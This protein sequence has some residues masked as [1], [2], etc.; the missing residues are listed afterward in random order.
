[1]FDFVTIS[2]RNKRGVVEIYPKFIIKKSK[3]L[4]IRGGDF[5]AAW[6]EEEKRWTTDEEELI[7]LIDELL[8]NYA[9]NNKSKFPDEHLAISHMWDADSGVIDK[10]HKYVQKQMRDN[11]KPL[12]NK[13]IF[14]DEESVKEDYSSIKLP[15]ALDDKGSIESYSNLISTLYSE[16]D[17]HKIEWCVGAIVTGASKRIH[18]F[19]V[20]YGPPGSGKSTLLNIIQMLF[21]GYHS[22][23]SA[24]ALG[25]ASADFSLA[26]F[27][28]NPLVAISH[29]DDLSRIEKNERLNSLTSHETMVV[30]EKHKAQYNMSFNSFLF[31]GTNKPVKITDSKSGIMRRLIDIYPSGDKLTLNMYNR[32]MN[33]I[34]FELGAIAHHCKQVYLQDPHAYD[35]YKP[36]LMMGES[37]DFY[38]F[39]LDSYRI[40]STDDGTTLKAAWEM[41][42]QYCDVAKVPY[43]FSMRI[44]K[45]ELNNY[46]KKYEE[47]ARID[48]VNVRSYYSIFKIEAF[49]SKPK[50]KPKDRV[51]ED[52][53]IIFK[54]QPSKL[55]TFCSNSPA[56]YAYTTGKQV[57]M[58]K[59]AKVDTILS[60]IDTSKL[61]YLKV[62]ENLIVVDFDITDEDGNKS[63]EENLKA[64]SEWPETY[65][66]LSK[67]GGGIHLHYIYNG[68]PTLLSRI[69]AQHIEI[70]VFTGN[71]SLRRMVTKCNDKDIATISSGL[72][73]RGGGKMVNFEAIKNE[74]ALRTII[75]KNLNKDYHSGTKP[76]V[77]FIFKALDDAYKNGMKYDVSDLHGSVIAFA[78]SSTNQSDYCMKLVPKM[79]FKSDEPSDE[80]IDDR[81]EKIIFYDIE[82]FPNLFVLN[83]KFRGKGKKINRMINPSSKEVEALLK[84]KMIGFN[85][86]RYDNHLVYAKVLG[87]SNMELFILSQ[88]IIMD[89]KGFFAEAWNISYTDVYDY[90]RKKQSLKKWQIE[91]GLHHQELGLPWDE[92]VPQVLWAKVAAYCD[93]DVLATEEVF[94]HTQGD[95][96]ARQILAELTGLSVNSTTNTLSTRL[97]FGKN[98]KPELNYVDLSKEFPGYEFI[99][100]WDTVNNKYIKRNMYRGKDLGFGGYVMGEPGMYGNVALIDV[101]SMHPNSIILMKYLGEYTSVFEELVKVRLYI[102]EGNLEAA[103]KLFGGRLAK[104]LD[105]PELAEDLADALKIV[106]NSVYGLTSA[107]FDNAFRDFRNENNIVALRGALFMKTLEDTVREKGFK[108]AH[109]KTDSIKIPDAT[110]EIIEFCK[111][112]ATKYGYIFEHEATY[113]RMALVNNAVYI[114][115]YDEHGLRGKNGKHANEWT[116]TGTQFA[117]PYVFKTLFS[118][119]QVD[120]HDLAETKEVKKGALYLN[121]NEGTEE[122]QL[123]FIGRVGLFSPVMPGHGGGEL[124]KPVEKKDGT[125]SYDSV[126]GA[127]GYRWLE[128]EEIIEKKLDNS[129]DMSFYNKM[130]DKAID[131]IG[132]FGDAEWFISGDKYQGPSLVNGH[133]DYNQTQLQIENPFKDSLG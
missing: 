126:T 63:F 109:V 103:K 68:D 4:M 119:E 70:K 2:T 52:A 72:P 45:S 93:N 99:K 3:D 18:K 111:E 128:T 8:D 67:S 9:K 16:D 20:L 98:K 110:P 133:P 115:K 43:P 58:N 91:L 132:K 89:R 107:A 14:A 57:P 85:N 39:M 25:S 59:W 55:D 100:E 96:R 95:F 31:I 122:D 79:K 66:E 131:T 114:A 7:Q 75:K 12:N 61:H 50:K 87:Y 65:A 36:V 127:K 60:E 21:D 78:A 42:K 11:Y 116:A 108:V 22:A 80:V 121:M 71:S 23:F 83:W 35:D 28:M 56:Q 88:K 123:R 15:Y 49:E 76:S 29:D 81:K 48:G 44:F 118:K 92:P 34:P 41:Y 64:A 32:L 19:A 47:R 37:N 124:V 33:Q 24:S 51:A 106:I 5:Y 17:R 102:K 26:P 6:I 101:A 77:D 1:M 117:V 74:K 129:I 46:F 105:D 53:T 30:N 97:I 86:R 125:I 13:L 104:Y 84:Y 73:M 90:A 130:V 27:K 38:N 113:E 54:H 94:E 10:W 120:I 40:F 69:Y 62:P 82:V 112:F